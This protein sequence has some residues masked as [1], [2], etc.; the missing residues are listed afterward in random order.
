MSPIYRMAKGL[1]SV[2]SGIVSL[3]DT[4]PEHRLGESPIRSRIGPAW[5]AL[6]EGRIRL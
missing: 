5:E 1:T 6:H 4:C 2:R 3:N